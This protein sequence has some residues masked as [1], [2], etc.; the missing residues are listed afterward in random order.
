MN[1]AEQ[2]QNWISNGA[3]VT[4]IVSMVPVI[5]LRGAIPIGVAMGL[6]HLD[7]MVIA[8][9]GNLVPVPFIIVFIRQVFTWMKAKMPKL[10]G[11]VEKLESRAESKVETVRR[12]QFFGLM[13]FVAIPLPGT[14]AWTGALVAGIMGMRLKHA[15]PSILLGVIIAGI[16]VTGI[17]YGFTNFLG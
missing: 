6:S 16:L 14:G 2:L 4:F 17:T 13:V 1:F 15:F 10:R 5:E 7:A 12:W 8:I 11:I 9:I 3:L